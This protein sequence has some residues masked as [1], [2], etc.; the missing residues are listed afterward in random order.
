M[1]SIWIRLFLGGVTV[2]VAA[3]SQA[4]ELLVSNYSGNSVSRYDT[5]TAA[6]LGNYTG[7]SISGTLGTRVGPNGMLYVC[8]EIN[9][10]IQRF[11]MGTH[12]YVDTIVNGTGLN[13]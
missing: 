2:G 1:R 9:N 6:F 11:D 12:A 13:N 7:G 3:S 4:M 5:A 8:S 10:T